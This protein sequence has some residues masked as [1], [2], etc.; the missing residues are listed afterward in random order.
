MVWFPSVG[1]AKSM[2]NDA[3]YRWQVWILIYLYL[4]AIA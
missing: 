2:E 4:G 1:E 3:Q